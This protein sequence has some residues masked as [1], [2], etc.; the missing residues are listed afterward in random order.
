M[1][2]GL[3]FSLALADFEDL[4]AGGPAGAGWMS[5]TRAFLRNLRSFFLFK[6]GATV[7]DSHSTAGLACEI[8]PLSPAVSGEEGQAVA[9]EVIVTNSGTARWLASDV[10]HGGVTI[11][12]HLYDAAGKLLKFEADRRPPTDPPREIGPGESVRC[13]LLLPPQAAGRYVLE[14][15]CV[16]NQVIWF[17]QI[18]SQPG[19][20]EVE[21]TAA[22]QS[23][24]A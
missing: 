24:P 13:R 17:A 10:E 4:V 19:R 23:P 18:G 20:V 6:P 14:V 12:A 16:S 2:N 9:V 11:G 7:V 8:F 1:F 3:P 15:D 22:K 21:I 5:S